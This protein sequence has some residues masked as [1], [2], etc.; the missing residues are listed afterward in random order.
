MKKIL[1]AALLLTVAHAH[2]Q[3]VEQ[4]MTKLK[5]LA[6]SCAASVAAQGCSVTTACGAFKS[7]RAQ[8]MHEGRTAYYDLHA[9]DKSMNPSNG[10]LVTEAVKAAAK[11]DEAVGDCSRT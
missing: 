9:S 8:L 2:G 1:G 11:A 4:D 5:Q 6:E 10:A 7:Y 3:T